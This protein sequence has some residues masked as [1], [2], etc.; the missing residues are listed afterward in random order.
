M[1]PEERKKLPPP[2][3]ALIGAIVTVA[4]AA[5]QDSA[6]GD[7]AQGRD[8]DLLEPAQQSGARRLAQTQQYRAPKASVRERW[9]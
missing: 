9:R 8:G 5:Q 7:V 4:T 3:L 6:S 2:R 1:A